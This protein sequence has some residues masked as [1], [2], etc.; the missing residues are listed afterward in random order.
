MLQLPLDFPTELKSIEKRERIIPRVP[1]AARLSERQPKSAKGIT[2]RGISPL[3]APERA[4]AILFREQIDEEI[5][6]ANVVKP[7]RLDCYLEIQSRDSF[8]LVQN[9]YKHWISFQFPE[10]AG[11]R[12]PLAV[13]RLFLQHRSQD[14][15]GRNVVQQRCGLDDTVLSKFQVTA[16][17]ITGHRKVFGREFPDDARL[18]P[19]APIAE[20][21]P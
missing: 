14:G 7:Q 16:H 17:H 6:G 4:L 21:S 3:T 11:Y 1:G 19:F 10:R 13:I 12:Q 5:H 15:S 20:E 2:N 8:A 9:L 18:Y